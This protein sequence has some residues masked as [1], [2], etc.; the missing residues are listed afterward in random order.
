MTVM[1][2][3]ESNCESRAAAHGL[4]S[5]RNAVLD[6]VLDH[7]RRDTPGLHLVDGV[8]LNADGLRW[9]WVRSPVLTP[10]E[11]PAVQ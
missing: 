8:A 2:F 9:S 6:R 3:T 1:L 5:A 4:G 7:R 10:E 11:T